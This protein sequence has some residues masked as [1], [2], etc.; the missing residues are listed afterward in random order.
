M[1]EGF[2]ADAGKIF[3]RGNYNRRAVFLQESAA[4][5]FCDGVC[6]DC[7]VEINFVLLNL[8]SFGGERK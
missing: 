5:I 1:L 8:L 3:G 2:C 7:G 4:E 6:A